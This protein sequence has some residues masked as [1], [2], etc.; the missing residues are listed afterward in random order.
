M[1]RPRKENSWRPTE[2]LRIKAWYRTLLEAVPPAFGRGDSK[3]ERR[4]ADLQCALW[5]RGIVVSSGRLTDWKLGRCMPSKGRLMSLRSI[6]PKVALCEQLLTTRQTIISENRLANLFLALDTVAANGHMR[7]RC[8]DLIPQFAAPWL[9]TPVAT[10]SAMFG[11]RIEKLGN[12]VASPTLA[13]R[14]NPLDPLSLLD[15]CL[16]IAEEYLAADAA[17]V[18]EA[19]VEVRERWESLAYE[20]AF[21]MLCISLLVNRLVIRELSHVDGGRVNASADAAS[22]LRKIMLGEFSVRDQPQLS[23]IFEGAQMPSG[24]DFVAFIVMCAGV[25]DSALT[26]AGVSVEDVRSIV[27]KMRRPTG[28]S[29]IPPEA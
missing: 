27:E 8:L 6:S 7:S 4:A 20:W 28:M 25:V 9:P 29:D 15:Y 21:D 13:H 17:V 23:R 22:L 24:S 18:R 11:W 14:V 26:K 16:R 5:D 12:R 19:E 2:S 1:A 3:I 10:G